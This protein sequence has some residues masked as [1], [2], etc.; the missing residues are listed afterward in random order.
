MG[1]PAVEAALPDRLL[2]AARDRLRMRDVMGFRP[3]L[4]GLRG[5]ARVR[6][7]NLSPDRR[8]GSPPLSWRA[9]W[10]VSSAGG[11]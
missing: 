5:G 11:R 2:R 6:G 1:E 7:W 3:W 10:F 9:V 8:Y 4:A